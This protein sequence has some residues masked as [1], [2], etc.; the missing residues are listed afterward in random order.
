MKQVPTTASY[1]LKK[2][3]NKC[4]TKEVWRG[5]DM[6]KAANDPRFNEGRGVLWGYSTAPNWKSV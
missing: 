2:S 3:S 4:A 1:P 6:L 5:L